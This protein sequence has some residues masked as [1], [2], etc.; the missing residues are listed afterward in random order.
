MRKI[1]T[2][3]GGNNFIENYLVER[4]VKQDY[5]VRLATPFPAHT[6]DQKIFGSVGQVVPLYCSYYQ[7]N[8]FVRA[9]EGAELVINLAEAEIGKGNAKLEKINVKIVEKIAKLCSAAGVQ[10]IIHF[11][12][13]G[14]DLHSSSSFLINK[15]KGEE[16]LLKVYP[17]AKI[18]RIGVCFG[19][20]DQFLNKLGLIASYLPVIPVYQ[21][22]TRL[23]PVYVGDI[24]DAVIKIVNMKS[25]DHAIYDLAGPEILSNRELIKKIVKI[26]HRHN[27]ISGLLPSLVKLMALFLQFMPGSLMTTRLLNMMKYDS[28]AD[29][30]QKGFSDLGIV[31]KSIEM[32]APSYL[33][34]FRPAC[35]FFELKKLQKEFCN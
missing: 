4:L 28:I 33:Y 31:P 30:K 6:R 32:I 20:E 1:A 15:K 3:I 14:A 16:V 25:F 11:S 34:C 23:Q 9:I 29:K 5:I 24:A 10:K 21:V 27:D 13:L 19:P 8:T 12:A 2:I 35:D 7:E 26:V 18:V 17:S 22:N